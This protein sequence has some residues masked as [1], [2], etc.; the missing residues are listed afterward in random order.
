MYFLFN[1][2]YFFLGGFC[3]KGQECLLDSECNGTI[4]VCRAGLFT[5]KFDDSYNCVQSDPSKAGFTDEDGGVIIALN[6]IIQIPKLETTKSSHNFNNSILD[7]EMVSIKPKGNS[8]NINN[9][10]IFMQICILFLVT[11]LEVQMSF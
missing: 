10:S 1:F 5:L 11:Y 6:P 4:C 3:A 7:I 2:V 8:S 9:Y